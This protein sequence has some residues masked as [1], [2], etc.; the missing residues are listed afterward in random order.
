MDTS[1]EITKTPAMEKDLATTD[2]LKA[3]LQWIKAIGEGGGQTSAF[4]D[5]DH[6][7]ESDELLRRFGCQRDP[8]L[9]RRTLSQHRDA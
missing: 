8:A 9:A 4:L 3:A 5:C 6:S 2:F 7:P 1:V